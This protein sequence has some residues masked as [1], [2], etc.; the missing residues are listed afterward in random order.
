MDVWD[1]PDRVVWKADSTFEASRA[2]V[3]MN[4]RLFSAAGAKMGTMG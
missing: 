4:E 3:S 1:V 2:D